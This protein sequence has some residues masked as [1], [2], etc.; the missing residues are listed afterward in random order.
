MCSQIKTMCLLR[1]KSKQAEYEGNG[2][3]NDL[4]VMINEVLMSASNV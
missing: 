1:L 2:S 4:T 3:D